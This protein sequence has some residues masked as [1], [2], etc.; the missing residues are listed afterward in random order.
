M[1]EKWY[2]FHWIDGEI[3]L[4]KGTSK[5]EA[6]RKI[7][8]GLG[9]LGVLDFVE[10]AKELPL[11]KKEIRYISLDKKEEILN[12]ETI[13]ADEV[14]THIHNMERDFQVHIANHVWKLKADIRPF[15]ITLEEYA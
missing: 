6:A 1:K 4:S 3:E 8:I 7:G 5:E 10:E 9:A 2:V 12:R 14:M 11:D 15:E 13:F